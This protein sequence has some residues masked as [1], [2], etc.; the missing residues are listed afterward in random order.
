[1][2]AIKVAVLGSDH[3]EAN[4]AGLAGDADVTEYR[5]CLLPVGQIGSS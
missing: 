5:Y 1:M 2:P 4:R 3:A